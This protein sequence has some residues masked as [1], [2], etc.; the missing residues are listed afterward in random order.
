MHVEAM[1]LSLTV[2]GSIFQMYRR[3]GPKG[4]K[5]SDEDLPSY[6]KRLAAHIIDHSGTIFG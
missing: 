5:P 1:P 6:A 2:D 3:R 4:T